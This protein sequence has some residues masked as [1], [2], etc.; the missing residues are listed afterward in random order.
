[1]ID[2]DVPTVDR[3]L[4]FGRRAFDC[5]DTRRFYWEEKYEYGIYRDDQGYARD[6]DGHTIRVHNRDIRRLLE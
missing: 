1:M 6:L 3:R 5:L 4:E 2:V